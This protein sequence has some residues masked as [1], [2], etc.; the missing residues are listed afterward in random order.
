M[1]LFKLDNNKLL[2]QEK[3]SFILESDI[4]ELVDKNLPS[5][6]GL[7]F[8]DSELVCGNLRMDTLAYDKKLNTFVIIEYKNKADPGLTDQGYAYKSLIE[9]RPEFF[10]LKYNE[11]NLTNQKIGIKDINC[12][13]IRIVFI[14][15]EFT[16]HQEAIKSENLPFEMW[17]INQYKGDLISLEQLNPKINSLEPND[18]DFQAITEIKGYKIGSKVQI[19]NKYGTF[20]GEVIDL[21]PKKEKVK[22][23]YSD[24]EISWEPISDTN[25]IL[26]NN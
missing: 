3:V 11:K 18:R 10:V 6:F 7:E 5:L 13:N 25:L 14:S 1:Y 16:K 26:K 8:I 23:K 15:P 12:S 9:T 19:T 24:G 21:N 2:K 20:E 22:V 17:K 4:K